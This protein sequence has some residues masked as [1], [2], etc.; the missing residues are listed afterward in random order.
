M[1]ALAARLGIEHAV[2]FTGDRTDIPDVLA[3]FD[4]SV[5]ASLADNLGGTLESLLMARPLVVSDIPGFA[6]AVLADETGVVVP[7][8]DPRCSPR[9]TSKRFSRATR[10]APR[11]TIEPS[12]RCGAHVR[13]RSAS[14]RYFG[15]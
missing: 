13:C 14:G 12:R 15:R 10:S 8:D 11:R 2:I 6:D 7:A 1:K 9:A 5:Q 4:V 3:A